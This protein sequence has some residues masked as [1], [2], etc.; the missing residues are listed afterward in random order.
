MN[1]PQLAVLLI[2]LF[3]AGAGAGTVALAASPINDSKAM[4]IQGDRLKAA[5]GF[6]LEKGPNKQVLAR[7]A[8]GGLLTSRAECSCSGG[9]GACDA[10]ISG[11]TA[12]C[13]RSPASPCSG[14]CSWK[15][16]PGVKLS[17]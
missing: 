3:G 5:P 12:I 8:G 14:T 17:K 9:T 1:K 4:V 16:M 6:V 10:A 2:A 11:D 15:F 13:S 7:P